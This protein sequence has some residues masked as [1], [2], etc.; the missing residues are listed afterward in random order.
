ME[1]TT[2]APLSQE[3]I[4]ST[5]PHKTWFIQR[6][7][8]FVFAAREQEAWDLLKNRTNWMRHDFQIIG[9]SD[10]TTYHKVL[11]EGRVKLP[12]LQAEADALQKEIGEYAETERQF[13]FKDLLDDTDERM[14]KVRKLKNDLLKQHQA[15]IEEI[16]AI[17]TDLDTSAFEAE[18]AVA[19]GHIEMPTN[20]DIITP[21]GNREKIIS[22][23]PR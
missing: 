20:Q 12:Q 5:K 11:R 4:A 18:L 8:G 2:N 14:I 13:K 7:D 19:R 15:K 16:Q 6:G 21:G 9:V 17:S 1:S 23:M 3:D 10:G 22:N